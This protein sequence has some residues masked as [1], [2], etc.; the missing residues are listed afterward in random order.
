MPASYTSNHVYAVSRVFDP[1]SGAWTGE[2][3]IRGLSTLWHPDGE[4][5]PWTFEQESSEDAFS[6]GTI[7]MNTLEFEY[8][9]TDGTGFVILDPNYGYFFVSDAVIP[10]N[11]IFAT[12]QEPFA[13][14]FLAGTLIAT[15]AGE[16]AIETLAIG[17]TVLGA[18]GE[19]LRIRW[20]GRQQVTAFLADRQR[21]WP[22]R[23][24]CGALAEGLPRRDLLVSPDHAIALDGLLVQA[25]ALVN[26]SSIT[27]EAAPPARF[28]YFHLELEGA[29]ALVLAEGVASES[30]VDNVTR[31][32][33]DNHAEYAAL[34][35]EAP[36]ATGELDW[37]RVKSA[38][39]LPRPLAQRL[40]QRAAAL[41]LEGAQAA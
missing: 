30:F 3:R 35:G 33:F 41:G 8:R 7:R 29:H 10:D 40:R 20:I 34:Y 13:V 12:S 21:R 32:R 17:D 23:I 1:G 5:R 24:A 26:G 25:A 2:F 6:T 28:T 15:P 19:A 16:R 36:S 37:P 27:R 18:T 11:T 4:P 31:S 38:R 39:Q 14:C 9:G 22:I